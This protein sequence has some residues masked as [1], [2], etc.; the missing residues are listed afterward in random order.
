MVRPDLRHAAGDMAS[1]AGLAPGTTHEADPAGPAGRRKGT[2]AKRLEDRYGIAQIST[3]DML[4]A[5]V[6]ADSADRSRGEGRDGGRTAGLGRHHHP[7]ARPASGAAGRGQGF[8]LDG[9]PRTVPQAEALDRLLTEKRMKLDSVI[10]LRV[11]DAAL[12]DRISGRFTCAHM[13]HGLPR[14]IQTDRGGR[15]L[16]RVRVARIHPAR[17]R[18][19]GDG[20][21]AARGVSPADR[22]DPAALR[23]ARHPAHRSTAWPTSTR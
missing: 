19:P 13:R 16:R 18:Q 7:H 8:I 6:A 17:R 11:D 2:Q 21:S 10:E 3:G 15:H 20:R 5:E 22:A 12:V 1:R 9:F 14:H 23:G 4:R